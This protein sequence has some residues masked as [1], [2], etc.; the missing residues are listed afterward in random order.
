M[1]FKQVLNDTDNKKGCFKDKF[2]NTYYC[3]FKFGGCNTLILS[4]GGE[5]CVYFLGALTRLKNLKLKYYAG[6]SCGAIVSSLLSIGYSPVEIFKR[7]LK[8]PKNLFITKTLDFVLENVENMFEEKGLSKN[9]TFQEFTLKTGK[10]LAFIA[11]NLTKLKEEIFCVQT[12]PNTPVV[13][14]IKLSCSLPIIFPIAKHN[15]EIFTDGIFFDNFP[16]KLCNIFEKRYKVVAITTSS[17]HY[18]KR[19]LQYYSNPD[20]FKIIII[21]DLFNKYFSASREDKFCMFVSGFNYVDENITIIRQ[22]RSSF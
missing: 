12:H 4:G 22:R 13:V 8:T 1:S 14:A 20:V 7:L 2:G 18:D 16:I 6:T 15:N 21:P 17:S 5:K 10:Q 9:I 19:L 3:D 11:S